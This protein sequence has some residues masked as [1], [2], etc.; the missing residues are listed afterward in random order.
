MELNLKE[1]V[2]TSLDDAEAAVWR[3]AG[4]LITFADPIYSTRHTTYAAI[5]LHA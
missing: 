4:I 3:P 5:N 1:L 2:S